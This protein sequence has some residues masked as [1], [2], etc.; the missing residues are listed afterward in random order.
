MLL[1][2]VMLLTAAISNSSNITYNSSYSQQHAMLLIAATYLQYQCYLQ[3]Q[4]CL[5]QQLVVTYNC[6]YLQQ[7]YYLTACH[8]NLPIL[9]THVQY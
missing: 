9:V 1:I 6:N 2:S 5:L 4:L 7:Y 8:S 3:Q